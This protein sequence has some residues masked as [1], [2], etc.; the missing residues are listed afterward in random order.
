MQILEQ[1]LIEVS[2]RNKEIVG[3]TTNWK[4]K[5][6]ELLKKYESQGSQDK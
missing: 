5:Y 4:V 2:N 3:D 1:E 6:E